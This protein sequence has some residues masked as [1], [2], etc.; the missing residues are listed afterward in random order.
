MA[1][2]PNEKTQV[3]V[4]PVACWVLELLPL[5]LSWLSGDLTSGDPTTGGVKKVG[6]LAVVNN[7]RSLRL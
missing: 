4:G 1:W 5:C 6:V 3:S 2:I 7:H